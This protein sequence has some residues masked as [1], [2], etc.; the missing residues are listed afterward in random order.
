MGEAVKR[1]VQQLEFTLLFVAVVGGLI[2]W[3]LYNWLAS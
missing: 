1:L 3:P 2:G